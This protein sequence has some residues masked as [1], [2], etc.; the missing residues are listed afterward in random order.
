MLRGAAN[1]VYRGE[2]R[3]NRLHVVIPRPSA[4]NQLACV[5]LVAAAIGGFV[6]ASASRHLGSNVVATAI[7]LFT[8]LAAVAGGVAML[9]CWK[10][11]GSAVT[12]WLAIA[13]LDRGLLSVV[14]RALDQDQSADPFARLI[15][16]LAVAGPAALALR[17]TEVDAGLKPVRFLA[18][19]T[20]AGFI[21]LALLQYF[22]GVIGGDSV[23][24]VTDQAA[25]AA[26][27]CA[28]LTLSVLSVQPDRRGRRIQRPWL[29]TLSLLMAASAFVAWLEPAGSWAVAYQSIALLAYSLA[30]LGAGT[31]LA[32]TVQGHSHYAFD[33][34]TSL[35]ETRSEVERERAELQER[36]HDLRNSVAALRTA[37]STLRNLAGRLD[38]NTRNSLAAALT[39]E[40]SRLQALIEP[41]RTI[42]IADVD[43]VAALEPVISTER[44]SGSH[45]ETDIDPVT[46]RGDGPAIAQVMQNL[47]V[48]ARTYAPGSPIHMRTERVADRVVIEVSD[49]GP[50]IPASE[51]FQVFERGVRG[52]ASRGRPGAGLGLHIAA[53]L[54]S[55]MGGRLYVTDSPAG[56]TFV[57]ELRRADHQPAAAQV[58]ENTGAVPA[59]PHPASDP[60]ASRPPIRA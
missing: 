29:T 42:E 30:L 58:P 21:L 31:E 45:I 11:G 35:E 4:T 34:R 22:F 28:W 23:S 48:N 10:I 59:R 41:A 19:S 24:S 33:L 53:R 57:M 54:V 3:R 15:I 17:R 37:D 9:G 5:V 13:L 14:Y 40:L 18:R 6:A 56:A 27:F 2:D 7:A 16:C 47:L 46:V 51:R 50:G 38:E 52:S 60:S 25:A 32:G 55:E 49:L 44:I 26:T 39:A 20:T 43:L 1:Q 12:G 8:A 36:L